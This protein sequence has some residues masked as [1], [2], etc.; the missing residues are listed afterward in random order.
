MARGPK[1]ASGLHDPSGQNGGGGSFF[2]QVATYSAGPSGA[3]ERQAESQLEDV[4]P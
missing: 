1:Y 4:A 2:G 3:N